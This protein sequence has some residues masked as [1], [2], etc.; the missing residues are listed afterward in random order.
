MLDLALPLR[1]KQALTEC[2]GT[3]LLIFNLS[4]RREWV[5]STTL[6]LYP[7]KIDSLPYVQEAGWAWVLLSMCAEN[8]ALSNLL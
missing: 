3:A 1:A 7:R 5:V 4:A 6:Q 2:R 8:L